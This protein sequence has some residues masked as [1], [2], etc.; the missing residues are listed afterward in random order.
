MNVSKMY[1]TDEIWKE[2]DHHSAELPPGIY[3]S[4][5]IR[6]MPVKLKVPLIVGLSFGLPTN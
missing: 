3:T 4:E 2:R 5:S 6:A 1:S